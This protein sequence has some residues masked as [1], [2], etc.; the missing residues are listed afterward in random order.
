MD[1]IAFVAAER[2][3]RVSRLLM[4]QVKANIIYKVQ[5]HK[6]AS[7]ALQFAQNYDPSVS[8]PFNSDKELRQLG[9]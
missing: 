3:L 2:S 4:S 7:G 1:T 5:Y 9:L 6:F 8:R